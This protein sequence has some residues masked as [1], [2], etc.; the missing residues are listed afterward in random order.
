MQR[1]DADAIRVG[2]R[3][4]PPKPHAHQ[5]DGTFV[6]DLRDN[7]KHSRI[8]R[9]RV[10]YQK[11]HIGEVEPRSILRLNILDR[12]FIAVLTNGYLAHF[13]LAAKLRYDG[14]PEQDLLVAHKEVRAS[15]AHGDF[16]DPLVRRTDDFSS[17]FT[18]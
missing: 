3:E 10:R 4:L 17:A 13:F 8:A 5:L 12:K 11:P 6:L 15:L 7:A 9:H 2:E 1:F 18:M 16:I 14:K